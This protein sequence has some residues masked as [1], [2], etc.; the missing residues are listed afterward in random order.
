MTNFV[1]GDT[2]GM[3]DAK[4]NP[5]LDADIKTD[6]IIRAVEAV[7]LALAIDML[8]EA[9]AASL[10]SVKSSWSIHSGLDS[11]LVVAYA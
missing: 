10:Y 2:I 7:L 11:I 3:R 8:G 6:D 4:V 9:I 1:V 5:T